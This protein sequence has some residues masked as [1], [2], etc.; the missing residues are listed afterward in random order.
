M[1][2]SKADRILNSFEGAVLF[3]YA[4]VN[5][6]GVQGSGLSTWV[7]IIDIG[8]VFGL[9]RDGLQQSRRVEDSP[10]VAKGDDDAVIQPLRTDDLGFRT[11]SGDL[12]GF[13]DSWRRKRLP[14]VTLMYC[15]RRFLCLV[16]DDRECP[17]AA[18]GI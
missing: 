18:S 15:G 4:P 7:V 12:H 3:W 2:A 8:M 5:I 10:A 9:G 14:I 11:A 17:A 13:W 16:A 1:I 6:R